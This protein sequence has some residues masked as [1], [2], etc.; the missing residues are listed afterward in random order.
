MTARR[1]WHGVFHKCVL[2]YERGVVA[3]IL[4]SGNIPCHNMLLSIVFEESSEI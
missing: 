2:D 4:P 1:H 3:C